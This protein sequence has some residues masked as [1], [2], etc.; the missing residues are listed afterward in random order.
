MRYLDRRRL[1]NI[2]LSTLLTPLASSLYASDAHASVGFAD[3]TMYGADPTG[4]KSS[5]AAFNAAFNAL[6]S[7]G[8]EIYV[9]PGHYLLDATL[10]FG[11]AP[12]TLR[13]EG[14]AISVL[15]VSH[16]A[17]AIVF[18]QSAS[19]HTVSVRNIGFAAVPTA[20]AS[21]LALSISMP[22]ANS[23]T[24]SCQ[25]EN[26]DFYVLGV[27]TAN[28]GGCIYL[29]N[30]W[31][32]V[33]SNVSSSASSSSP[34][35]GT[36]FVAL[37]NLTVDTRLTDCTV[38]TV[39]TAFIIM[40]TGGGSA[41]QGI[42]L[43]NPVVGNCNVGFS[44]GNTAFKNSS[45]NILGLYIKGGEFSCN[46]TALSL[47]QVNSGW[48]TDTHF[49]NFKT[50]ASP[51]CLINGCTAVQ[52]TN[53]QISGSSSGSS[54]STGI[55]LA[56]L[57]PQQSIQNTFDSCVFV[58]LTTAI[59]YGSGVQENSAINIRMINPSKYPT[60]QVSGVAIDNSGNGTNQAIWL[61]GMPGT[62][63]FG[64]LH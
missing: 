9:P 53:C 51:T 2:G 34:A 11:G 59:A 64:Y 18:N 40:N 14:A 57:N 46:N 43:I 32:G 10:S 24:P 63:R 61:T 47:T 27:S 33:I 31:R 15:I 19:Q 20:T 16:P 6:I 44:S 55:A 30:V 56:N 50:P 17:T 41:P 8:G 5:V 48:I 45:F 26:V 52:M 36:Y 58:N 35:S 42:H 22:N 37:D 3:V 38:D 21:G 25:V 1:L 54:S 49:G 39:D 7:S 28:F 12:V 62:G 4:A 13:G 29:N 60:Y 23:N